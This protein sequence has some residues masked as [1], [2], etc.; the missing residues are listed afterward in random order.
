[1]SISIPPTVPQSKAK[2]TR[3][4]AIAQADT[5]EQARNKLDH[6]IGL[7]R[8]IKCGASYGKVKEIGKPKPPVQ[9]PSQTLTKQTVSD[10]SSSRIEKTTSKKFKYTKS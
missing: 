1:M 2:C 9:H 7:A 3:C 5:F 8:G 4:G 6:A 10:T